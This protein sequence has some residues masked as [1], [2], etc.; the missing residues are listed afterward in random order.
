MASEMSTFDLDVILREDRVTR[1][2]SMREYHDMMMELRDEAAKRGREGRLK[3]PEDQEEANADDPFWK[4]RDELLEIL[5]CPSCDL[6]LRADPCSPVHALLQDN[7]MQH[8][9]LLPFM[10]RI[11][12]DIRNTE[13]R[14][15]S[16][17]P[18]KVAIATGDCPHVVDRFGQVWMSKPVWEK[19]SQEVTD[20][21]AQMAEAEDLHNAYV[22][23]VAEERLRAEKDKVRWAGGWAAEKFDELCE[24][25]EFYGY[26]PPEK[27][28]V[29]FRKILDEDT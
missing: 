8:S 28:Q 4:E 12:E 10:E 9:L 1:G 3:V 26:A 29:R 5:L 7:P 13:T 21:R 17:C 19:L 15:C 16:I 22:D 11:V 25:A 14:I 18:G 20:T 23:N 6:E 2:M 27:F 24:D